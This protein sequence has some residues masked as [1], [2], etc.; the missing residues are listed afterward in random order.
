MRLTISG[1]P[2]GEVPT[3]MRNGRLGQSCCAAA[4]QTVVAASPAARPNVSRRLIDIGFLPK[5]P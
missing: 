1:L 5:W 4:G 3:R 2:P